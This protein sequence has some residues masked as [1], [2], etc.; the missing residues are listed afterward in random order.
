MKNAP[1]VLGVS[2]SHN[3][4]A[5][6]LHGSQIVAAIQDERVLRFKRLPTTGRFT[7]H[8]IRYCLDVAGIQ[9]RDLDLI[10]C[11]ETRGAGEAESQ[12]IFLN[13]ALRAGHFRVPVA[14]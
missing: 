1:W 8:C 14:N 6:L 4:S 13:D 3:G 11:S 9:P 12:D 5:C 2:C 7:S 10:V